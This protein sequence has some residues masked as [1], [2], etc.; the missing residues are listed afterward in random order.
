MI[1]MKCIIINFNFNNFLESL[2]MLAHW[3]IMTLYYLMK[4]IIK[5]IKKNII[6]NLKIN[7]L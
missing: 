7:I 1:L 3:L 2:Q 6:Q 5:Q 4:M